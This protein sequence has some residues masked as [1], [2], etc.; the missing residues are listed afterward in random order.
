MKPTIR[1]SFDTS[2]CTTAGTSP[3]NFEKSMQGSWQEPRRKA[4]QKQKSPADP[5]GL[6]QNRVRST[7][8]YTQLRLLVT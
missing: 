5:A 6:L 2:S 1:T 3:F 7:M 4:G 8:R